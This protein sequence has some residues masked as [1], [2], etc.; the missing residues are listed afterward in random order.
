MR[1]REREWE[2]ERTKNCPLTVNFVVFYEFHTFTISFTFILLHIFLS[3][4]FLFLHLLV[5]VFVLN[6]LCVTKTEYSCMKTN[7]FSPLAEI[8]RK[9]SFKL[10]IETKVQLGFNRINNSGILQDSLIFFHKYYEYF[11]F[12]ILCSYVSYSC[13]RMNFFGCSFIEK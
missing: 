1:K 4:Y 10:L 2:R 8:L 3:N 13:F 12:V 9:N 11:F 6:S 5:P 7:T